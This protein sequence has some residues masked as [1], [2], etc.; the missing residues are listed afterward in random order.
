MLSSGE[1]AVSPRGEETMKWDVR[2]S[3][4]RFTFGDDGKLIKSNTLSEQV[5]LLRLSR[6]TKQVFLNNADDFFREKGIKE[7][8]IAYR[9]NELI[10]AM[11]EAQSQSL[12]SPVK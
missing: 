1:Q 10:T 8:Q 5:I 7:D 9:I 11:D 4:Q 6:I 3:L 12:L 2:A